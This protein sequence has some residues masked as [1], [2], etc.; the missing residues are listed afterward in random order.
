MVIIMQDEWVIV[1]HGEEFQI[2]A[3]SEACE[4]IENADTYLCFLK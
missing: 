1:F 2:P 3:P 4:I